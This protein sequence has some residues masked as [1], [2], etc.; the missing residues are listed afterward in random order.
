MNPENGILGGT[1]NQ[2]GINVRSV[3]FNTSCSSQSY[4]LC[5]VR[6]VTGKKGDDGDDEE[7]KADSNAQKP[8]IKTR[9]TANE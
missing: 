4:I 2:K 5:H 8:Y 7:D 3:K 1:S 6:K 9:R